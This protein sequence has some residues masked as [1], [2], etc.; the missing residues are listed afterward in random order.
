MMLCP[1]CG[2][3]LALVGRVHSCRTVPKSLDNVSEPLTGA[4]TGDIECQNSMPTLEVEM[5][6]KTVF[7]ARVSTRGQKLDLQIDAAKRLGVK[8]ADIYVEK[9]SGIRHDR[10]V[11]AK[12]MTALQKGDTLACYKLD[13]IGR[14]LVHLSKLLAELEERGVHF[15]T[16]E[17][18][19]STKG[20]TGRLVLNIMGSI[21]Q[22]ERDLILERTRAGL[23]AAKKRGKRLGAPAK[24]SPEMAGRARQLMA[25]D[26]LNG[27]DA[28]R[29]LG[30]SRRTMFRG[31]R[32]A[33]DHDELA[34]T[35]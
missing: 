22:F 6:P 18:G 11:L 21:A 12:V 25:K 1:K 29:V 19:L 16:V 2:A 14:S 34:G 9:A 8:T 7:Y 27:E 33:R 24:W 15:Q 30:V 5:A 23:E 26:G 28:A 31:L 17:D 3:N 35:T 4:N 32:A 20:S 10:P 13:R